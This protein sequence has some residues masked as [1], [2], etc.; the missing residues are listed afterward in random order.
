[1]HGEVDLPANQGRVFGHG[2]ALGRSTRIVLHHA[3]S[4]TVR[5][6]PGSLGLEHEVVPLGLGRV[7][8]LVY[9]VF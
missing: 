9:D 2:W 5:P 6:V 8:R 7:M 4:P 3:V 1:M